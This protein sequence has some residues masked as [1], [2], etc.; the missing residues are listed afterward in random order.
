M[1]KSYDAI[2][3]GAG[4]GGITCAALLAKWGLRPLVLEKNDEIGGKAVT[5]QSHKGFR[6][7]RWP[8][9]QVP[10]RNPAFATAFRELGIEAKLRPV[11]T[12]EDP[13]EMCAIKY[14]GRT[15]EYKTK[16]FAQTM[17]DPT[18][19]FDLFGLNSKEQEDSLKFMTEMV[20]MPSE[21]VDLLDDVTMDEFISRYDVPEPLYNYMALHSNVSLTEPIDQAAASEQVKIMQQIMLQGGGGY[22][23]GGFGRVIEDMAAVLR[24]HGGEIQ[25]NAKVDQIT[26]SDGRVRGVVS[27]G[28]E[29]PAPMVISSAGI[30]PTVLKLVGTKHF[31]ASYVNY[32]RDLVPTWACTGVQYFLSREVLKHPMY[33]AYSDDSW[34][35]TERM[36]RLKRGYVPEEI[37]LLI[38]VPSNYDP[39]MSPPGK[40]CIV[41]GTICSPD[42][43]A[44]EVQM[45]WDKMDQMLA[46]LWPE[47]VPAI[48]DKMYAGPAQV[49]LLTREHVLPGQ[50]GECVGMGQIVGQCGRHKPS[51]KAP[52]QGLFY[53]GADAGACGMGTN[54]ATESGIKVARMVLQHYRAHQSVV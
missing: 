21:K 18:P 54:Q 34:L 52:I 6:Y 40:Q 37:L 4:P 9:A 47:V 14:R 26:V 29:F 5:V 22:Y 20:L 43:G 38:T 31:D 32:V 28:N 1:M 35:N 50:G 24:G 48:E 46:R 25:T 19:F 30:Q 49:S 23:F 33:L 27:G 15:G 42:P 3:I 10:M 45:L 51:P 53:V 39:A 8:I 17:Q 7:E 2:V 11:L 16:G 13:R 36:L 41:A 44:K 12:P